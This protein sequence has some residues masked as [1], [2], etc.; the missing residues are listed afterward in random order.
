M[1]MTNEK[2][3]AKEK[4][5]GLLTIIVI[6]FLASSYLS[7]RILKIAS[8]YNPLPYDG[9]FVGVVLVFICLILL[10]AISKLMIKVFYGDR[11][12]IRSISGG[13]T[14]KLYFSDLESWYIIGSKDEKEDG[15]RLM[16][17][18]GD[19]KQTN[20]EATG[21]SNIDAVIESLSKSKTE[22]DKAEADFDKKTN[23]LAPYIIGAFSIIWL[24]I[25]GY[26]IFSSLV[27]KVHKDDLL[28]IN[29]NLQ[30]SAF[31]YRG[32]KI[33][34]QSILVSCHI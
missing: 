23:M 20:I 3:I 16:L 18:F 27:R 32:G 10:Y 14:K 26:F 31:F 22:D 21:F 24:L 9:I 7:W 25:G 28:V 30:D 19:V 1:T 33:R 4:S 6:L 11:V 8:E 17:R 15:R 34:D 12:E 29:G 2:F 13:S 5:D